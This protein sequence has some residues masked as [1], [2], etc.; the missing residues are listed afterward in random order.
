MGPRGSAAPAAMLSLGDADIGASSS[1]AAFDA[2]VTNKV[3][4]PPAALDS[5]DA[6]NYLRH[7]DQT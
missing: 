3:A 7:D 5:N 2:T 1:V 6:I 4:M